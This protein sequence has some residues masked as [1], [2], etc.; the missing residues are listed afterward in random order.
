VSIPLID[1]QILSTLE[2][3]H[4]CR[5]FQD[6]LFAF[7]FRDPAHCSTL[8]MDLRV[9][10]AARIRQVIFSPGDVE[11][12]HTFATWRTAGD[13]LTVIH[14][15]VDEL[16]SVSFLDRLRTILK[17]GDAPLVSLQDFPTESLERRAVEKAIVECSVAL[18]ASKMFF[19]G[20]VER[21]AINGVFKSYP[22]N[23]DVHQAIADQAELNI[24]PRRLQFLIEQQEQHG[25]D[26][27]LV[28]ARRGAVFE[29]VFTHAGSGT[30]FTREYPNILRQAEASDVRDIMAIM[31][32]YVSEGFLKPVTE[33]ELLGII[34]T[35][36]VYS[37]NGQIVCA[38]AL[39]DFGEASELVKLCTLP[40]YQARGRARALVRA[41]LE[42]AR[43]HGK[44]SVF[45]LT[46]QGYVGDFFERLGF[47]P[48]DRA[49]LPE[50]WKA[51]YDFSRS[52]RAYL[53]RL[54]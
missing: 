33:E 22:S 46:V 35:F 26:V 25:I 6:V 54:R 12:E 24:S 11:L 37:V 15:R 9:V 4:Y 34:R 43:S 45:A 23:Q 18:G 47:V 32:P 42:E 27:V 50:A 30:L 19:P 41:L 48:V 49:E 3:L 8:L 21:L 28:G 38:A 5:R 51:G 13:R 29:E 1:S 40:R 36:T 44:E 16:K 31:Q 14:A 20:E 17:Q 7:S 2:L 53:Y 52:S 10:L 39:R